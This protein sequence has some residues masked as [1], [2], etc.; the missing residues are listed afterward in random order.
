MTNY[1]VS[2]CAAYV[3]GSFPTAYLVVKKTSNI[4]IRTVGSGNVGGRNALDVT[5]KTSVGVAVVAIDVLKGIS[6]VVLASILFDEKIAAV[7]SAMIGS[8]IGHCYPVWL[9]FK[10]GRGLATAA[11]AFLATSWVWVPVWLGFYFGSSKVLKNIHASSVTALIITPFFIWLL[12]NEWMDV[13]LIDAFSREIFLPA[14]TAVMAICLTKHIQPLREYY[15]K[16]NS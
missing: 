12:P 6:S 7:S 16:K 8:V 14:G 2:F 9:K 5:G 1:L 13:V 15:A 3:I 4:D 11:G 10:G